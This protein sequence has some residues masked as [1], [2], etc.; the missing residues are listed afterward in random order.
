MVWDAV[1]GAGASIIG[2]LLGSES[3]DNAADT[4]LEIARQNQQMQREF[5]QQGIRWRVSDAQAAG[6]HPLYA[7]GAQIPTY[8]PS[9]FIPGGGNALGEGIAQAGQHLGRAVKATQTQPE[10]DAEY[11][12]AIKKL[13][14]ERGSLQNELLRS[15]IVRI[16]QAG[17]G[18]S[19]P[20]LWDD[21]SGAIP[22]QG[23]DPRRSSVLG[24]QALQKPKVLETTKVSP[25]AP[26]QEPAALAESGFSWTGT[27]WA[28]VPSKLAKER[29]EDDLAAELSW[30][31]RNRVPQTFVGARLQPPDWVKLKPDEEWWFHPFLQEYRIRKKARSDVP[32]SWSTFSGAP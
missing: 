30:S 2:G 3:E 28:P 26:H 4:Q 31:L 16:N 29:I 24:P 11:A 25:T 19:F 18:R 13:E 12:E 9:Q 32:S 23:D 8:S 15:Q 7:L 17:P 27:G 5:A 10:K 20:S 22:G 14:L 21:I 6:I 1:I